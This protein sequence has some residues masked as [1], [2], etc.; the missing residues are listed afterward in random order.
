MHILLSLST[1][2]PNNPR[3]HIKSFAVLHKYHDT[4]LLQ[5][6]MSICYLFAFIKV[7]TINSCLYSCIYTYLYIYIYQCFRISGI[8]EVSQVRQ[9]CKWVI[10]AS[11]L[12]HKWFS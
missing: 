12:N 6:M 2:F 3:M 11:S 5:Q 1:Y 10:S 4:H 9:M 7:Q 8:D